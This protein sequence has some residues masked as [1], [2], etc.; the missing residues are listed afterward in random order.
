MIKDRFDELKVKPISVQINDAYEEY[1]EH[2]DYNEDEP[3]DY[4]DFKDYWWRF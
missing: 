1:L 3:M 2:F 4:E